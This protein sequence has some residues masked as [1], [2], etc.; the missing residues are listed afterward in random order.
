MTKVCK[1]NPKPDKKTAHR[2]QYI[3]N[4]DVRAFAYMSFAQ[5]AHDVGLLLSAEHILLQSMELY[6]RLQ[7]LKTVLRYPYALKKIKS[8][9]N[10]AW[11]GD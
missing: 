11:N 3:K 7:S 6:W 9:R 4:G 10:D 5:L 1:L 2:G 8:S